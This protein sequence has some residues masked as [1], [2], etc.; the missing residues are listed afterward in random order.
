MVCLGGCARAGKASRGFIGINVINVV[1][2]VN[3][4]AKQAT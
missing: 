3:L 4:D 1:V 2:S